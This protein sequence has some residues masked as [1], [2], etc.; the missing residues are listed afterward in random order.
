MMADVADGPIYL[1]AA[2]HAHP[3]TVRTNADLERALPDLE[4][5]WIERNL[6]IEERRIAGSG[7][8]VS[9]LA[10]SA[11]SEALRSAAWEGATLDAIVCGASFVDQVL[12]ATA[13]FIA[14]A[15]APTAVAFDVNAACASFPVA[16]SVA[17]AMM[18]SRRAPRRVAVCVAEH[19]T[20]WADDGDPRSCVYWGDGAG[21][22]LLGADRPSLGFE[23]LDVALAGDHEHPER[24]LTERDGTFMH[25]GPF[26]YQQVLRLAGATVAAVLEDAGLEAG[27][28]AAFVGHQS[29]PRLLAALGD[30]LGI[31]LERQWQNVRWAGNQGAAGVLTAFS[32]GWQA[33][34]A[35][36]RHGDHVVLAAVGGGYSGGAVLLRWLDER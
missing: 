31:P 20:V 1:L 5:G 7:D 24:V 27:D 26:S 21:V 36:L 16:M 22:V 14:S 33:H 10:I 28:V 4:R 32:D 13:S 11:L 8:R 25:D 19:P 3:A 9:D 18:R 12:P 17:V 6:G 30:Q 34:G 29:S 23:V 35:E 15:V 2:A